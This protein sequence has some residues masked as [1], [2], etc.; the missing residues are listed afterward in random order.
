MKRTALLSVFHKDGIVMFAEGLIELGFDLLAS[1]GT[2]QHLAKAGLPVRDVSELVGG[3]AI[4]GHKVVTL[5]RELH[6]GLLADRTPEELA[7]LER[8]QVPFIDLV[9]VDLYPLAKVVNDV[10]ATPDS[11][12]KNTDIGGPTMLRSGAKGR[13][14]VICDP[15]DRMKV[16]TWLRAGEP[17]AES[18]VTDLAAKAEYT[19][20]EYCMLSAN[21]H[22]EGG[23]NGMSGILVSTLRYGENA[24]QH[25]AQLFA[26]SNDDPLAMHH[27]QLMEGSADPSYNNIAELDRLLQ[28]MTHVVAGF[29]VNHSYVPM[30]A[31]GSKHG[32]CCGAGISLH[33]Q[34]VEALNRMLAGDP[35]ALFGGVVML[36]F[37]IDREI[38]EHLTKQG[39][40]PK[41][42]LDGVIAPE[43]TPE[44]AE[45][46]GRKEGKC[47]LLVNPAL[48]KLSAESLDANFRLR[49][50]RGGFMAQP[51]YTFIL[52]LKRNPV[53]VYP[54]TE[55]ADRSADLLLAW[56]IGST[57]TSNTITLVRGGRLLGN[58]VGQQDRV[59]AC[60]LA[61]AR[62]RAAG[63][64][65][66]GAVAY[67]DSFFPFPD[68]PQTLVRAGIHTILAS[69][70]SVRDQEVV[71]YCQQAGISLYLIPDH[72]G[73]GFYGH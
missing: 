17:D 11:V 28:T 37:P 7:E 16:L 56:A 33:G 50:V 65:V 62:A 26:C 2:A 32:N 24:W 71:A 54:G 30:V 39:T 61:L 57:S 52:D 19:I 64:N 15:E 41:R 49:Y 14:I 5:S 67:S 12:R 10:D 44:A 70:G 13:R 66:E 20:A 25:P 3:D 60:E 21:F 6:A 22:S 46:L 29:A 23:Y 38:A 1:G 43:I 47:R 72:M 58:G 68:G 42:L 73:R 36:N 34:P 4:L 51:N 8:L 35:R 53:S 9:C 69:S 59:G 45:L 27:F 63:H 48:A 31:L 40:G 18:F 55:D